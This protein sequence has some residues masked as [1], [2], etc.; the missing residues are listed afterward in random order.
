MKAVVRVS[1]FVLL[2]FAASC[3]IESPEATVDLA[4]PLGVSVTEVSNQ[5]IVHFWGY[6]NEDYFS[7]YQI[8]ISDNPANLV[9]DIPPLSAGLLVNLN[10]YTNDPTIIADRLS[11]P[12]LFAFTNQPS[13]YIISNASKFYVTLNTNFT[14]YFNVRSYS[15]LY[16]IVSRRPSDTASNYYI[17]Q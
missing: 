17:L 13:I 6:N 1:I 5:M 11:S 7:G 3:G 8:Y 10:G 12:R 2:L 14:Y 4:P 15:Q 16:K 9:G